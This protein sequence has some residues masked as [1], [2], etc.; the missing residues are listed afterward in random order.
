MINLIEHL[1]SNLHLSLVLFLIFTFI[2]SGIIKGFLG[3][4]LPSTAMGLLTLV[5]EPIHAISIMV[6]PI[7]FSNIFQYAR[8]SQPYKTF[9]ELKVFALFIIVSI[10]VTSLFITAY[11]RSLL[12]IAIG[13]SMVIFSL[14]QWFGFKIQIG[15]SYSFQVLIGTLSGVLGGLSS[16]WSPPVAMYLIARDYNKEDFISATGFLFMVGGIPLGLGL[17]FA[18]VLT[19]VIA[20]QSFAA[21]IFVLIGFRIGEYLRS[22]VNQQTFRNSV[23]VAF[24]ILGSRLIYEGA[25]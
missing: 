3:L 11:P 20:I 7:L 16:I 2:V 4:G 17:Y 14:N 12:T 1:S 6:A 23:L 8:S 15:P 21:L 24:I 18:G 5:I 10:F 22:F 9:T 25:I 13:S 19:F